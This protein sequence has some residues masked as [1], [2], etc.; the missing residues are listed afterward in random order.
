MLGFERWYWH[1][2]MHANSGFLDKTGA[3]IG[4][5]QKL[6]RH[7]NVSTTMN[8][9]GNSSLEAKQ[10]ARQKVTP[11][12]SPT[13]T[14]PQFSVSSALPVTRPELP[15]S[16]TFLVTVPLCLIIGPSGI[17]LHDGSWSLKQSFR[18]AMAAGPLYCSLSTC[19]IHLEPEGKCLFRQPLTVSPIVESF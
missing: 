1:I 8:L 13:R 11:D 18:P 5:Q 6:M 3:P 17:M 7:A 12:L 10:E 9:Y 14:L 2:F 16:K 4:E 15:P 19:R